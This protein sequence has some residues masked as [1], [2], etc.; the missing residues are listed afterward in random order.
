MDERPETL[1]HY[2]SPMHLPRILA[3]EELTTTESNVDVFVAHRGPD[4]LWAL[5]TAM[6]PEGDLPHGLYH[7]KT[8]ARITFRTPKRAVRWQ[9]WDWTAKMLPEWRDTLVNAAGGPEAAA[10]WWIVPH[11]VISRHWTAVEAWSDGAWQPIDSVR[12]SPKGGKAPVVSFDLP[13]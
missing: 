1:F 2:T 6:M 7:A 4:V 12:V 8:L 10:H 13:R 5:D 3:T 9:D 11:P